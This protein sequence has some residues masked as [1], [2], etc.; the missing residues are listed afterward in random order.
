MIE[1]LRGYCLLVMCVCLVVQLY[2]LTLGINS[3]LA[4]REQT[5]KQTNKQTKKNKRKKTFRRT[6]WF[7]SLLSLYLESP[8]TVSMTTIDT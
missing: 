3:L 5:N 8:L 1:S 6:D 4:A 2:S 7:I